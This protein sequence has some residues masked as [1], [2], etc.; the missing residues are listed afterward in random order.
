M[1]LRVSSEHALGPG[2]EKATIVEVGGELEMHSAPLLRQELAAA[3]EGSRPSVLV[4]LS[5]LSFIDSTGIGVLVG[6]LKRARENK[7]SLV[8]VCPVERIRR[9]FEIT[10]LLHALPLYETRTQARE[11]AS[12]SSATTSESGPSAGAQAHAPLSNSSSAA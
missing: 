8:L 4:D 9:V 5:S 1:D 2:G 7:G 6:A 11:A 10:G 3:C 12:L